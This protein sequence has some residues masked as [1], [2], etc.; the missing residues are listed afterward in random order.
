M[1][2]ALETALILA[3]RFDSYI[4]GFA[5]RWNIAAFGGADMMGASVL[6]VDHQ[7][8]ARMEM[9][10]RTIFEL[11]MQKHG[12]PRSTATSNARDAAVRDGAQAID[13]GN[14]DCQTPEKH[15]NGPNYQQ[16]RDA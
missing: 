1:G 6:Q 12:V 11:F 5:L 15:G 16:R 13:G 7:E 4:E 10:A 2:S 9:Q 3:R 14:R 8:I